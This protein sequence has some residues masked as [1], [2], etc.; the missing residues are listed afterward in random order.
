MDIKEAKALARR[1]SDDV[2]AI[3]DELFYSTGINITSVGVNTIETTSFNSESREFRHHVTLSA[4][5]DF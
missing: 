2:E 4:S 1:A 5:M 3:L